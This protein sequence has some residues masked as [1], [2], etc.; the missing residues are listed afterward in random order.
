MNCI[1]TLTLL[2]CLISN[3]LGQTTR[4]FGDIRNI[5]D[6]IVS[7]ETS[8]QLQL[9]SIE[10][11][12]SMGTAAAADFDK[13]V[14]LIKDSA[15]VDYIN[16]VGQNL[17]KHSDAQMPCNFKVIDSER[18]DVL[19]L[20]G[21][22]IYVLSGL[23]KEVENEAEFAG[24][25]A[26]GIAHVAARHTARLVNDE[27]Y[28]QT[29]TIPLFF[30]WHLANFDSEVLP[31]PADPVSRAAIYREF[32]FEADQL[33]IQYLWNSGYDPNAYI[34]LLQKLLKLEMEK[35]GA[36][37]LSFPFMPATEDRI[38]ASVQERNLFPQKDR[39]ISNTPEFEG[40]KNVLLD[41]S[42]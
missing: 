8:E 5:G 35:S 37:R 22:R 2:A 16:H 30:V 3:T 11:E 14:L 29:A 32:T 34:T 19:T 15:V 40:I 12:L 7:G 23:I 18:M 20:P 6:R 27:K 17:V 21:G 36:K 1:F 42:F 24:A 33:A 9:I 31:V 39:Y 13:S 10:K 38:A 26:H 28:L 41:L 25:V 4:R